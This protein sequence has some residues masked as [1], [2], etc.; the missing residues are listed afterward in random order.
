MKYGLAIAFGS[1][2]SAIAKQETK[3]PVAAWFDAAL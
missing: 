1:A 3:A 2:Q